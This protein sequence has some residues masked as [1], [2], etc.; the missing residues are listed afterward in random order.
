V[1]F[2]GTAAASAEIPPQQNTLP[3]EDLQDLTAARG[4]AFGFEQLARLERQLG[5]PRQPV[6]YLGLRLPPVNRPR[7][8]ACREVL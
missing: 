1:T 3:I 6:R 5:R 8:C 7:A 2:V 4:L